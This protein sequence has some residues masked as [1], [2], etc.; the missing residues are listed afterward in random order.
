MLAIAIVLWG[1][2]AVQGAHALVTTPDPVI[3]EI[4]H[5]NTSVQ[6]GSTLYEYQ[7]II[8]PDFY[9]NI[10]L[11]D[12]QANTTFYF[13]LTCGANTTLFE[14]DPQP[15]T[16][17]SQSFTGYMFLANA[18]GA[19]CNTG[20]TLFTK[21]TTID[22]SCT[23]GAYALGEPNIYVIDDCVNVASAPCSGVVAPL[24]FGRKFDTVFVPPIIHTPTGAEGTLSSNLL[25]KTEFCENTFDGTTNTADLVFYNEA[26]TTIIDTISYQLTA[27]LEATL[28]T[29]IANFT[30]TVDVSGLSLV[31]DTT[32]L[33]KINHST[34]RGYA[35]SDDIYPTPLSDGVLVTL[36]LRTDPPVIN[37]ARTNLLAAIASDTFNISFT[38]PEPAYQ[39]KINIYFTPLPRSTFSGAITTPFHFILDNVSSGV[40]HFFEWDGTLDVSNV[41]NTR[42]FA[43][44]ID[45]VWVNTTNPTQMSDS[46]YYNVTITYQD[47]YQNTAASVT[48]PNHHFVREGEPGGL[49]LSDFET[50]ESP[51]AG[52]IDVPAGFFDTYPRDFSNDEFVII[53]GRYT[54]VC[55][56]IRLLT[57]TYLL[58]APYSRAK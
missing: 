17:V 3:N 48:S 2:L 4:T 55:F 5:T 19:P 26:G 36:D 27:G 49:F 29:A 28:S 6:D 46:Q 39:D 20:C 52:T 45:V 14:W 32:Y 34:A 40:E 43:S 24:V 25:V 37:E 9:Y 23:G 31:H 47:V 13:G 35:I 56:L 57:H 21:W 1:L 30:N 41:N 15:R 22:D 54:P 7:M 50:L 18:T 51:S 44:T 42:P 38:I 53:L 58:Y 8:T 12:G 16:T 10:T 33:L 11:P